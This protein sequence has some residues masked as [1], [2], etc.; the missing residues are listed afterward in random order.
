MELSSFL[1]FSTMSEHF[2]SPTLAPGVPKIVQ[3]CLN[4][5]KLSI[6]HNFSDKDLFFSAEP[7]YY[8][9]GTFLAF[10]SMAEHFLLKQFDAEVPKLVQTCS[11]IS[12]NCLF[13]TILLLVIKTSFFSRVHF[14]HFLAWENISCQD[15]FH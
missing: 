8:T 15:F 9:E 6:F 5:S 7:Q 13:F 2:L 11:K 14:W 4:E 3:N 12:P 10:S 1:A